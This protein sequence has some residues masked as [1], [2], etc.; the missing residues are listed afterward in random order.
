[1]AELTYDLLRRL[2]KPELHCHLDGSLRPGTMLEIAREQ[3]VTLPRDDAASLRE[4]MRVDDARNLEDYLA[5]FD[6]TISVMQTADAIERIAYELV[7]DARDDGVRY[8]EV[9]NAPKLNTRGSLSLD[10]VV[11]ATLRGL[12]RGERD[13]GVVARFIVC[14]LRHWA[15]DVSLRMAHLAVAYRDRGVV[16]FDLAGPESGYAAVDHAAAFLY[17]REHNLAV[18]CHAG[19]GDGAGSVAQAVHLLGANRIGHGTRTGDDSGLLQYVTDRQIALEI[20]PT[21]N[22]QTHAVDSFGEH[23]IRRYFESG[24]NVTLN[25]DSR[26]ISGVTL[27][28]EYMRV[29]A[30]LGFT[31]DD[32]VTISLNGFHSAFL[33]WEERNELVSSVVGELERDWVSD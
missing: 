33:P 30:E 32:L 17:A 13:F 1:M 22:E 20:C 23:P 19:E 25:T 16:G 21:S 11:C 8:I 24:V 14:S 10:D 27:T 26:L 2:P 3:R 9:R 12:S 29:A 5:R 18:T 4:Y 31:L 6:V 15:P 7:E 28:S